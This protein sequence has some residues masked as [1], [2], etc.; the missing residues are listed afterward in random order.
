MDVYWKREFARAKRALDQR[1]YAGW[2]DLWH[3]HLDWKAKGN[4]SGED[5]AAVAKFT[6]MLL[7]HAESLAHGRAIQVFA[8]ICEDTGDNAVYLHSA[9]PHGTPFPHAFG[10]IEWDVLGPPE[11]H[12]VVDLNRY[13]IGRIQRVASLEFIIQRREGP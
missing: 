6:Y 5:R 4:R 7:N 2:F 1:D 10:E 8:T 3:L 9:N 11:L 13:V 12:G